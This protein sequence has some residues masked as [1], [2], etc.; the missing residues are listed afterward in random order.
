[1]IL[2]VERERSFQEFQHH[3]MCC[4]GVSQTPH[5]DRTA[6]TAHDRCA[7]GGA[8]CIMSVDSASSAPLPAELLNPTP[9]PCIVP[10]PSCDAHVR[11]A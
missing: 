9:Q 4:L 6:G 1:M 10:A 3:Y 7:E 2:G 11:S 5:L 8:P